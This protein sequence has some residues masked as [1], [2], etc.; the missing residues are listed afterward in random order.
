MYEEVE[1]KIMNMMGEKLVARKTEL[2]ELVKGDIKGNPHSPREVV[3]NITKNLI[4]RGFIIPLYASE[5][6]FAITQKG[7]RTVK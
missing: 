4:Q 2:I 5:T 7:M 1:K 6:T 3:D